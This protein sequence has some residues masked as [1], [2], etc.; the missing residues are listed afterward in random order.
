MLP[1]EMDQTPQTVLDEVIKPRKSISN[2]RCWKVVASKPGYSKGIHAS[3]FRCHR[4]RL[5]LDYIHPRWV[6]LVDHSQVQ[7]WL[8][9]IAVEVGIGIKILIRKQHT[10]ITASF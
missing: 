6:L 10:T 5:S 2:L 7:L 3:G 1:R 8:D 4:F 9:K